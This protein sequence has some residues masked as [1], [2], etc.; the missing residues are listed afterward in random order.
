[1]TARSVF[2]RGEFDWGTRMHAV[3]DLHPD[4]EQLVVVTP[5]DERSELMVV[6]NFFEE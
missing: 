1:M 4:G 5:G 2:L 6:L 3:Y